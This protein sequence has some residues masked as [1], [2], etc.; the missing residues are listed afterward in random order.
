MILDSS[1]VQVPA[2]VIAGIKARAMI[3]VGAPARPAHH[4]AGYDGQET[5]AWRP[6]QTSADSATLYERDLTL[7]R[8][9]DVIR[10][11]PTARAAVERLVDLIV[12]AGLRLSAK[13]DGTAL[14]I[15]DPHVL[16]DFARAIEAEWRLFAED[17][18]YLCD[19]QRRVSINGLW[20]VMART[21]IVA[22]EATA[23]LMWREAPGQRYATCV[24]PIDPDRVC[25]PDG[26][27]ETATLRGGVEM[28]AFGAPIAYH[29]RNAHIGDWW[30]SQRACTWTRVPRATSWGRPIF[31]HGFEP[32]RE[33]Q[34]R[35]ISPFAALIAQLRMVGKFADHELASAAANALF[36]AFVESDL[37]VAEVAERMTPAAATYADRLVEFY[38][39][40]PP[41]VGGV[42]IPVM[43]PGSKI[44]MNSSPRQTANFAS[45]QTVFVQ[46]IASAL[47]LSYEQLAMDF[48]NT[49]Y[50][51]CRA[52]LNEVWRSVKRMSTVFVEQIVS[53][54]YFAF[55]EESFDRR[56]LEIPG[57]GS[58]D[59]FHE[60]PGAFT[61]AR[62]IGPG[63]GVIDPTKE[64]EAAGMRMDNLTSTLEAECAEQG[65]DYEDVLDQLQ[66]EKDELAARGLERVTA[67]PQGKPAQ[68]GA[69]E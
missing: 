30:D 3:D 27:P 47:G 8:V 68:A 23:V 51:S 67:K 7:A 21:W 64:A 31:V 42:R 38:T 66:T 25:N 46:K 29:V 18:R 17:P 50:S 44:T 56:R 39:S 63:R 24:M 12:G 62:W 41:K 5:F 52:A 53:P 13:P 26:E 34:T 6:Q 69:A 59:L 11:D 19:A 37:P 16:R 43:L 9:R 57:G 61:R 45:F 58:I 40:N 35:A 4:A 14:G 15:K 22:G 36:A 49:N 33:G 60:I 20:R 28:D 10:N 1:G 65:V 32:E 55:L 48:S 54:V 2:D